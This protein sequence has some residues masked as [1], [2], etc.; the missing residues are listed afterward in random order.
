MKN[1]K[2]PEPTAAETYAARASDIA[3]LM[4]VLQMELDAHAKQA[5]AKPGDWGFAGDLYRI[6]SGLIGL[7]GIM[8]NKDPEDI[9]E[10][11]ADAE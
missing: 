4:D 9:E 11:L 7:V 8:S 6:R 5:N 3:R 1:A 10:F 2:K